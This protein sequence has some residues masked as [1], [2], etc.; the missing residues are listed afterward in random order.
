MFFLHLTLRQAACLSG[1][2][3]TGKRHWEFELGEDTWSSPYVVDGSSPQRVL[4]E[5]SNPACTST[6][7]GARGFATIDTSPPSDLF[8]R[9]SKIGVTPL[10]R[11]PFP[12]GC[13]DLVARTEDGK[14]MKVRIP[15][16]GAAAQ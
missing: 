11:F 4:I 7:D 10:P 2:T 15:Q 5:C 9:G 12:A 14:E 3:A 1:F 16:T 6:A 13:V 8:W